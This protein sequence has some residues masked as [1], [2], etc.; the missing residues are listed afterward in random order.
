M[1]FK[2]TIP[3]PSSTVYKIMVSITNIL[4]FKCICL[5]GEGSLKSLCFLWSRLFLFFSFF[6]G[7]QQSSTSL[8]SPH[9]LSNESI[10][11]LSPKESWFDSWSKEMAKTK[12]QLQW[13]V[14]SY[15]PSLHHWSS[16]SPIYSIKNVWPMTV[17][18]EYWQQPQTGLKHIL[19]H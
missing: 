12:Q 17:P 14:V 11:F 4:F 10:I 5:M 8:G 1:N 18:T 16:T 9:T 19:P 3:F 2:W 6:F 13:C 7:P 15:D